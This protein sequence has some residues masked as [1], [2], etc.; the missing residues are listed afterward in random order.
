MGIVG[1]IRESK[2]WGWISD[3][4]TLQGL[5]SSAIAS[6]PTAVAIMHNLSFPFVF[7]IFSGVCASC[8]AVV[9][10]GRLLTNNSAK[11]VEPRKARFGLV[12]A[13]S[14]LVLTV[15]AYFVLPRAAARNDL[16]PSP[17][18]QSPVSSPAPSVPSAENGATRD[19]Q[20]QPKTNQITTPRKSKSAPKKAE[21]GSTTIQGD[22]NQTSSGPCSPN[23]V[24][25]ENTV[26]PSCG[27]P[28]PKLMAREEV[29][30]PLSIANDTQ[31]AKVHVRTDQPIPRPILGFVFSGPV[32]FG[33]VGDSDGDP[34]LI[35]SDVDDLPWKGQ[36]FR[37]GQPLP[38]SGAFQ[39]SAPDLFTTDEEFVVTVKSKTAVRLVELLLIKPKS[40]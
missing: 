17:V 30:S 14:S 27:P 4:S 8:L 19:Q 13:F 23:V 35:G 22:V 10:Y 21:T 7:L 32:E 26:N 29:T 2:P 16:T 11:P 34:V 1:R 18:V 12:V 6:I 39:I 28:P 5:V 36:L 40:P 9:H 37:G 31:I 15:V 25:N 24:G 3:F 33:K 38:N 20:S